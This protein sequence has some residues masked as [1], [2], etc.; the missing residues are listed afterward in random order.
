MVLKH[1]ENSTQVFVFE[2]KDRKREDKELKAALNNRTLAIRRSV[3]ENS[4][5]EETRTAREKMSLGK[6]EQ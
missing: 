1:R 2:T 6:R 4:R 3:H 5:Q